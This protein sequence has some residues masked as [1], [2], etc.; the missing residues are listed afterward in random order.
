MRTTLT[1]DDDVAIRLARLREERGDSLKSVVNEALRRGL[2]ALDRGA[3]ERP[4]Y[5]LEPVDLGRCLVPSLDKT[6]AVLAYAEGEDY[7]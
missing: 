6:S 2:D 3:E 5:R 7:K 4:R 1:I